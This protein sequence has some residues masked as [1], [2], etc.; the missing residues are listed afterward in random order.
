MIKLIVQGHYVFGYLTLC[1]L[2]RNMWRLLRDFLS[3]LQFHYNN[4]IRPI[5][6]EV[7]ST[8]YWSSWNWF[9]VKIKIS[10]FFSQI[11]HLCKHLLFLS[12][13][14]NGLVVPL[15]YY[16]LHY[17]HVIEVIEIV[18]NKHKYTYWSGTRILQP[19]AY[20]HCLKSKTQNRW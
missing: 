3:A 15:N 4:T 1:N 20:K 8:C 2:S 16:F 12:N 9:K 18:C 17:L 7:S 5:H 11:Y 13:G 10:S 19:V 14:L 6:F